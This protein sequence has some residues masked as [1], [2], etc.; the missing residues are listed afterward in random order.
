MRAA[1]RCIDSE[2]TLAFAAPA[3]TVP[4]G[5]DRDELRALAHRDH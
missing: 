1:R 2:L 4:T 5:D 3:E